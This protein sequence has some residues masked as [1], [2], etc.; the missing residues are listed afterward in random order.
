MFHRTRRFA[1]AIVA[2]GISAMALAAEPTT[3]QLRAQIDALSQKVDALEAKQI[4]T[5]DVDATVQRVLK[6]AQQRSQFMA[7]QGFTAGY[8]KGKFV[9]QSADGKFSF[10]PIAQ[11]QI[12]YDGNYRNGVP[13]QP[14][15]TSSYDD[16]FELRRA[17]FGFSGNVV[18]QDLTYKFQWATDRGTGNPSLEE[19][20]ARYRFAPEFAV[21]GGQWQD[22][23]THESSV[24]SSRQL[25]V[26]QSVLTTLLSPTVYPQGVGIA[27]E[28]GKLR[29][30]GAYHDG[31]N[32]ANTKF[33]DT[34]NSSGNNI[35]HWGATG[36]VEWMA[37]GDNWKEY[38]DFTARGNKSDLLVFGAGLDA[39]QYANTAA[40]KD[41]YT[42]GADVQWEPL[43]VPGLG[44][45]GAYIGQYNNQ[46]DINGVQSPT[47]YNYGFLIQAGYMLTD[48]WEV[49]ARY[50]ITQFDGQKLGGDVTDNIQEITTGVNYYINGHAAKFTA[51]VVFL[52]NG[53][54]SGISGS[55]SLDSTGI[56]PTSGDSF[57]V[58]GR[59]QFQLL[60]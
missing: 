58:V 18:S 33:F 15:D 22:F 1:P 52:P 23:A 54:D 19:G 8:N 6:D 26:E 56:L 10:S 43:S 42:H 32:S 21:F 57:E 51:D 20:W 53:A 13:N 36:R 14:S 30:Q 41:V 9:I 48:K 37:S 11:L 47:L 50:D 59:V 34:G 16:G 35:A 29:V 46:G 55:G 38:D 27:Y 60:L 39:T 17:K 24:R 40:S 4:S 5:A 31:G 49:F 2:L 3:E 44:V 45:F 28:S 12:R 25:A 7:A